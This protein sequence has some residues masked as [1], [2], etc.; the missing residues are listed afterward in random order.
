MWQKSQGWSFRA[1]WKLSLIPTNSSIF[2]LVMTAARKQPPWLVGL[3]PCP[4]LVCQH[5]SFLDRLLDL[6][7]L[8]PSEDCRGAGRLSWA[9][10]ACVSG[11]VH[12]SFSLSMHYLQFWLIPLV[13]CSPQRELIMAGSERCKEWA[14]QRSWFVVL[15][16]GRGGPDVLRHTLAYSRACV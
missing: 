7:I 5:R 13:G 8:L 12:S 16:L 14:D 9:V 11:A 10:G 2:L 1:W 3:F 6:L 4:T 15:H